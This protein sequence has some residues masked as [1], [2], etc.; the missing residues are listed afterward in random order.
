M[1]VRISVFLSILVLGLSAGAR[2]E[3]PRQDTVHP[4]VDCPDV[5]AV[6]CG[7]DG[8]TYSNACQAGR[9]GIDVAYEG[10][11]RVASC[12]NV[13][14]PVCGEDGRDYANACEAQKAGVRVQHA[15]T[16]K[17]TPC[18]MHYRPVCGKDGRT[19]ANDCT[20]RAAGADIAHDGECVA[21]EEVTSDE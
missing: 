21:E 11:C 9:F 20:A 1:Q 8:H 10:L 2:G 13:E 6:V 18:P 15:G 14:D 7:A 3:E 4:G 12:P 19:Y 16:C 5:D 17:P